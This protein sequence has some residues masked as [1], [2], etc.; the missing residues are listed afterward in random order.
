MT[1]RALVLLAVL[2][3]A[4]VASADAVGPLDPAAAQLCGGSV[5]NPRCPPDLFGG[6][7]CGVFVLGLAA[8]GLRGM[9]RGKSEGSREG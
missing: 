2:S 8:V 6:A 1:M 4:D 7:C 9:L 5:H 3:I